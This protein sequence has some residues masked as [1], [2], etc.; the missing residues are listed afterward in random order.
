[1]IET[2]I[3]W[4]LVIK[5]IS[6]QKGIKNLEICRSIGIDGCIYHNSFNSALCRL[7]I[8]AEEGIMLCDLYDLDINKL[9]RL[10]IPDKKCC[11]CR[12]VFKSKDIVRISS[13]KNICLVCANS[14]KYHNGKLLKNNLIKPIERKKNRT[15]RQGRFKLTSWSM[16]DIQELKNLS[17]EYNDSQSDS[18]EMKVTLHKLAHSL[19][20][21][22]TDLEKL[23]KLK[24]DNKRV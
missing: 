3:N 23:E 12:K 7:V 20:F 15:W 8:T 17:D 2:Y 1:M 6:Q 24:N 11:I 16:Y 14:T 21:I 10:N 22:I 13:G 18:M 4:K 19:D 5:Q 9:P